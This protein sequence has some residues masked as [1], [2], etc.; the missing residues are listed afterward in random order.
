MRSA[1]LSR[2]DLSPAPVM[3]NHEKNLGASEDAASLFKLV[4]RVK[5]HLLQTYSALHLQIALSEVENLSEE[6]SNEN[7][8]GYGATPI[9]RDSAVEVQRFLK[10]LPPQIP[11]PEILPEPDGHIGLEWEL[12]HDCWLILSFSGDG[13]IHYAGKFGGGVRTKGSEQFFFALPGEIKAKI[14]RL[15]RK[16]K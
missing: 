8:D 12:D 5:G 16:L 15:F 4:E 10:L 11:M 7:W 1:N 14:Y 13:K 6:L 3:P 9:S 2:A